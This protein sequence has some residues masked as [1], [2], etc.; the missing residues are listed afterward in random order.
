MQL[1]SAVACLVQTKSQRVAPD[2]DILDKPSGRVGVPFHRVDG[3]PLFEPTGSLADAFLHSISSTE[4]RIF[5]RAKSKAHPRTSFQ[6]F[7]PSR[8]APQMLRISSAGFLTLTVCHAPW[9]I[10]RPNCVI[11][12]TRKW[13]LKRLPPGS[14]QARRSW[15]RRNQC[16]FGLSTKA[17]DVMRAKPRIAKSARRQ[18]Q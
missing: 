2:F 11:D 9:A 4:S 13:Q 7:D 14:F 17:H 18:R 6:D 16:W 8:C 12:A 10:S 15:I 5:S 3:A 1:P